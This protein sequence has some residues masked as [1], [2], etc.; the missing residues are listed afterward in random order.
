MKLTKK[1]ITCFAFL[2]TVFSTTKA[3]LYKIDLAGKVNKASLIVEGTVTGKHSFWNEAHTIIY[4]SNT[5]HVYKLF[6]GNLITADIEVITRGGTVGLTCLKVSDVVQL[7]TGETGMFFLHENLLKIRSPQTKKILYDVYSSAQGFLRYGERGSKAFAPFAKYENIQ[8]T[9]YTLIN[10]DTRQK[11]K[12]IDNAFKPGASQ[13][14]NSDSDVSNG[15]EAIVIS[16]FS[17]ATVN[18]GAINDEANNILTINGS[19]FGNNPSAQAGINFKDANN[20]NTNPDFKIVFNSPYIVSWTDTKI[21]VRVPDRAGEGKFSVVAGDGTETK[22]ATDLKVLFS[23]I[24][25]TFKSGN[26]KDVVREPRLMNTNNNGG[27][28][29]QYSTSTEGNGIDFST[30]PVKESFKRALATWKEI[31]GVNIVE[32]S[33]TSLQAVGDDETN[34]VVFDNANTGETPMAD[35]VL[36]STYSWFQACTQNGEILVAQKTGFDIV[37]RNDKVSTGGDIEIEEGPCFPANGTYD[38]EMIILH[39]LGH[40]LNLSHINDD[41]ENSGGGYATINPSKLMHYA[42][43]DYVDRRSPDASALMGALYDIT[44]QH[45]TYGNCGLFASEMTQ[46]QSASL[47]LDE[48]PSTFPSTA[49]VDNTI[50]NFDLVHATSN[51]FTDPSFTQVTCNS[52]GTS[53]T[54][55][56]YYAF[57]NGT[58]KELDLEITNYTTTPAALNAC[59]G[60][61]IR[62]ALYDVQSCPEGQSY[63]SPVFCKT[64]NGNEKLNISGLAQNH[65][66]LLYFDGLR[67]TKA[68]FNATFNGDGSVPG[69]STTIEAFPNPV[70]NGVTNI[71]I[72]NTSGSFYEYALFDV[73]GKLLTRGKVSVIQPVQT[74]TLNII[75]VAAGIYHLRIMDDSGKTVAKK[76]IVKYN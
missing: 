36:E 69:T 12:I 27:Y 60:Q 8:Q 9:L 62:L 7:E 32:G 66:Y 56:A 52:S 75:N 42:I 47:A 21:Q 3:Q 4:T 68:S 13:V 24:D 15:T 65:K 6:K 53:V 18:P 51:K 22:S 1:L 33:N 2:L 17:P 26:N 74:F 35:G 63:P 16:S 64:F 28:S 38:I 5:V 20:D 30:S 31:V 46:L 71:R 57:T 54:N 19:G 25:A 29:V 70:S 14:V 58:K 49:I 73:T 48:C 41:Y 45:N 40:A 23:I 10:Q 39:E 37:L 43:L 67:N 76:K 50:V 44:P 61:G 72:S 34:L 11:E 59:A 55:N